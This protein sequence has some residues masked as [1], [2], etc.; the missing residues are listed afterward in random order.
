MLH[1]HDMPGRHALRVLAGQEGFAPGRI[2]AVLP[3]PDAE[4]FG[5]R[6]EGRWSNLLDAL[7]PPALPQ[8]TVL[9]PEPEGRV[10]VPFLTPEGRVEGLE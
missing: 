9:M 2:R 5:G 1:S 7:L 3:T 6:P 4:H 8:S 10:V